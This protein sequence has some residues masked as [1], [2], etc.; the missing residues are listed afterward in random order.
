M[1]AWKRYG[2]WGTWQERRLKLNSRRKPRNTP[3]KQHSR[4]TPAPGP[5]EAA[6]AP[7]P[8][9]EGRGETSLPEAAGCWSLGTAEAPRPI[10][11]PGKGFNHSRHSPSAPPG[12]RA[13]EEAR[14]GRS[15]LPWLST[16]PL[17][18]GTPRVWREGELSGSV[19]REIRFG[20]PRCGRAQGHP[21]ARPAPP[22]PALTILSPRHAQ[23]LPPPPPAHF[24]PAPACVTAR[25]AGP[26][27]AMGALRGRCCAP[28]LGVAWSVR[29]SC[30]G[31][32]PRWSWLSY[33][34]GW[35]RRSQK[36]RTN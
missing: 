21:S 6:P 34:Q 17:S 4:A 20:P 15:G 29:G 22:L 3:Q 33:S 23:P 36:H 7:L 8:T 19:G 31:L 9:T 24:R 25:G 16:V 26:R 12:P 5:S 35:T 2:T 10:P 28:S 18:P 27:G 11:L 13:H 14:H 1:K 32:C 30:P